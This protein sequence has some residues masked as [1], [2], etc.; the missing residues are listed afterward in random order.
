MFAL[1][2]AAGAS[3]NAAS[4]RLVMGWFGAHQRGVAMGV[5]QMGQPLG[6]AAAALVMPPLA[7]RH[8]VGAALAAR[9]LA[10][11]VVAL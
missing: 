3:V 5:R 6:V 4:G 7:E 2:G 11:L 10:C 9:R 1:I 8:G